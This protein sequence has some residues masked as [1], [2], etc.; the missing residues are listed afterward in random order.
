T[1]ADPSHILLETETTVEGTIAGRAAGANGFG[2]DPIFLYPPLG[3][4]TAELTDAEKAS[5]SHRARAFKDL[6]RFFR[7][8]TMI[9]QER[10]R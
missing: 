2:Y 6:S 1:L 4:T 7:A 10:L 3:R 8:S 5:I 9:D